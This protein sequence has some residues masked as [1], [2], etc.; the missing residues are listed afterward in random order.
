MVSE[1][2]A[3]FAPNLTLTVTVEAGENGDSEVHLHPGGQAFWVARMLSHLGVTPMLCGPVGGETGL[4]L[5]SLIRLWDVE[6]HPVE[7]GSDSP[8]VIQDR[9]SGDREV[10]AETSGRSLDRHTLDDAYSM[11]LE[12]ALAAGAAV[13]TGQRSEVVPLEAYRRLGNDLSST[14]VQVVADLHGPE[15]GAFLEG[16]RIDMLKVSDEDLAQDGALAAGTDAAAV[17]AIES[18]ASRGAMNVVLSRAD[19]PTVARI[20]GDIYFASTPRLEPADFRGAGDSM[21][22]ALA[23]GIIRGLEPPELLRLGCAAGAA[24]VTR[25]GLGSGSQDL[26]DKLAEKVEISMAAPLAR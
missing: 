2:A 23:A 6:F 10:V 5:A 17:S 7:A 9:R 14:E 18:L 22:A 1:R 11:F 16:G 12:L 25:H 24:N 21:T 26:V 20:D 4:A 15:L 13:I 3:I 8:A 19:Q